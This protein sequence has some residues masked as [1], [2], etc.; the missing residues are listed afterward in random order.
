MTSH[1]LDSTFDLERAAFA[2]EH[3]LRLNQYD[4]IYCS[5]KSLEYDQKVAIALEIVDAKVEAQMHD[6]ENI[7]IS[8]LARKCKVERKTIRKIEK[9]LNDHGRVLSPRDI[10]ANKT[11]QRGAGSR[12]LS[13]LDVFILL[14]LYHHDPS[15]TCKNY[16]KA[17]FLVT[18]TI[19]HPTTICRFFREGF[20]ISGRMCKTNLIPYDKF[21]P[22]NYEKAL[23]YMMFISVLKPERI[24]FGDEKH[25]EGADLFCRKV[26]RNVITGEVPAIKTHP[27][28]RLRYTIVGFC[29]ID[30]SV[31]PVRYGFT[32]NTNNAE[33]FAHQIILAIFT[34]WLKIGD[35][36]V[37]DNATIHYGGDNSDLCDWLWFNYRIFVLFLPA[38]TPEWN[39]IE[40]VWNILVQRLEHFCLSLANELACVAQMAGET[41]HSL[42]VASR[43]ILDNVTHEEVRGCYRKSGYQV[44]K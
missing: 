31:T 23:E 5:G 28:F 25:L 2:A 39:P 11:V 6:R 9:E 3:G 18:G 41:N 27:D 4:R 16:V 17:L 13:E 38:R 19:V 40:L 33:N 15:T 21:Q 29:G 34:G 24:K 26:R 36:L 14:Q 30:P 20:A 42:V 12:S 43:T 32:V 1:C 37:L 44:P 22:D 7:N 35:I 8:E 10:S